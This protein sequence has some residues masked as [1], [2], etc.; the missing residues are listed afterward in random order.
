MRLK[1]KATLIAGS[2]LGVGSL[3]IAMGARATTS[4][5]EIVTSFGSILENIVDEVTDAVITF[6]TANWAII[7]VLSVTVGLVFFLYYK[8]RGA[9]RGK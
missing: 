3:A 6:L 1:D 9:I 7:A 4:T 5:S 8:L 2:M